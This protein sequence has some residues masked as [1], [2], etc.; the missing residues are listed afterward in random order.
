METV[1]AARNF[2][3]CS[4]YQTTDSIFNLRFPHEAGQ[5]VN[6]TPGP[7]TRN[8][9]TKS[10]HTHRLSQFSSLTV[11][12][13]SSPTATAATARAAPVSASAR[14]SAV[15]RQHLSIPFHAGF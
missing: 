7:R 14:V 15:V 1:K 8:T 11:P 2:A 10:H 12:A 6:R 4:D 5:Y 3:R 13:C 9:R